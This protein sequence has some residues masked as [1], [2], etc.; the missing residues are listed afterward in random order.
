MEPYIDLIPAVDHASILEDRARTEFY[1]A[2]ASAL[3]TLDRTIALYRSVDSDRALARTLAFAVRPYE[4]GGWPQ[5][6][7]A[8]SAQAA[9]ML[10]EH[11]PSTD[12]AFAV[13]QQ[14]WLTMFQ[15]THERGV[16]LADRAIG[17]AEAVGDEQTIIHS[18]NTKGCQM[19]ARGDSAGI[20][21]MEECRRRASEH[22][23]AF[24]EA[25]VLINLASQA[26][27]AL[28][29]DRAF[30]LTLCSCDVSVRHGFPANEAFAQS[31]LVVILLLRGDW[32]AAQDAIAD[33]MASSSNVEASVI[34]E[35]GQL[36]ARSG[37][38]DAGATIERGL[39]L[40]Q[41]HAELQY[42]TVAAAAVAEYLWLTGND[43]QHRIAA[44][45]EILEASTDH[46]HLLT[47]G[48]LAFWLWKLGHLQSIPE[49][50][51][52][53]YRLTIVGEYAEAAAI[54]EAKGMPYDQALALMHG[55]ESEQL[56]ALRILEELGAT[57]TAGKVRKSLL[58]MGAKAPRGKAGATK[59]HPAHLTGRQAEV[60]DL[61]A[62]GLSNLEIADRLFISTHT[63]ANHVAAILMK[64]DATDRHAAVDVARTLG[65]VA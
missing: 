16:A 46:D 4:L 15:G 2:E 42:L 49:T 63:A 35:L 55:D 64:L 5:D 56:Q 10:E 26:V 60:L 29:L 1:L 14:A 13:S 43:R 61:L 54:W 32:T 7:R 50:I 22:G 20:E 48:A 41:T 40:A 36:Q 21:V 57:A 37:R 18:L 27:D 9:A 6:A 65:L 24:E 11:C 23:Y 52:E 62:E 38:Q 51:A 3:D 19:L 30:E 44:L 31:Q 28:D 53:P 39:S 59:D 33:V 58:D 47:A 17:L 12:L 25:R 8:C 34:V 45:L